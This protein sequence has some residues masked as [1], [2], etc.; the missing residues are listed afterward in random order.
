[1]SV[2][3][4]VEAFELQHSFALGALF[5]L[6]L[7]RVF[8]GAG[9]AGPLGHHLNVVLCVLRTWHTATCA[10]WRKLAWRA[11]VFVAVERIVGH[12]EIGAALVSACRAWRE[13]TFEARPLADGGSWCQP[14]FDLNCWILADVFFLL[15][16]VALHR[17]C[18]W[19]VLFVYLAARAL[20]KVELLM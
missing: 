8:R 11:P 9:W 17:V 19:R 18:R 6:L 10:A 5:L 20:R 1:M 7:L 14:L 16:F 13:Q 15:A 4:L 2:I 12:C 3:S